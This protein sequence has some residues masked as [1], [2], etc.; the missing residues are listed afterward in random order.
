MRATAWIGISAA[1]LFAAAAA[2]G[3]EGVREA[4][5]ELRRPEGAPQR[6][7]RGTCDVRTGSDFQRF[8]ISVEG[9][10]EDG[11]LVVLL[12]DGEERLSVVGEMPGGSRARVLLRTTLEGGELPF[13]VDAVSALSGRRIVVRD[14]EERTVLEGSVPA[15]R[16]D[17]DGD[18]DGDGGGDGGDDVDRPRD[19]PRT[20]RTNMVATEDAER[21]PQGVIVATLRA[22]SSALRMEAGRLAAETGYLVYVG[23][24]DDFGLWD[25]VRTGGEGGFGLSRDTALGQELPLGADVVTA[26]AGRRVEVRT[27]DGDVVLYGEIPSVA[28]E[29]DVREVHEEER[30]SDEETGCDADVE[31]RIDPERG[32]ERLVV[33]LRGLHGG[34]D[35]RDA[36]R[37][38]RRPA[39]FLVEDENGEMV[40]ARRFRPDRRG[41]ARLA[42]NTRRGDDLPLREA[43][44]R[45]LRGR[46]FEAR[47]RGDLRLRGSLPTW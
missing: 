38:G 33:V 10:N 40:E 29:E 2:V 22:D 45:N 27:R 14:G 42:W 8:R 39:E 15:F 12:G 37:R 4:V 9:V 44:L 28:R 20:A 34:A 23:R 17:G 1:A 5:S 24:G 41:R 43:S 32:H 13:G 25:D 30:Q 21:E 19:V 7:A 31:V 16:E 46:A 18:G 6:D 3:G 36:V 47:V 11:G 35:G 26:L